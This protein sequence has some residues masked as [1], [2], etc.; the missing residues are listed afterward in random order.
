M[1]YSRPMRWVFVL[2]LGCLAGCATPGTATPMATSTATATPQIGVMLITRVRPTTAVSQTTPTPLPTPTATPTP[3]PIV[4]RIE[5]GDTLLDLALRHGYTVADIE[6]LNPGIQP[7]LLQI[8]QPVLL[9][10]PPTAVSQ[11]ARAT[12][13]PLQLRVTQAQL[14]RTT[15]ESVWVVGELVNEGAAAV[16]GVRLQIDVVD[17]AGE[18]VA[19]T[20]VWVAASLIPP[21]AAAPFG[22]LLP[23]L[24]PDVQP[25]VSVVGGQSAV[26]LGSRYVGVQPTAVSLT[27]SEGQITLTGEL[28]NTG[29]HPASQLRLIA[30][31]YDA[32][33]Q[34]SGFQVQ[35]WADGVLGV[36][37]KR[38]F[39]LTAAP[40]GGAVVGYGLLVQGIRD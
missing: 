12:P 24:P 4:Y 27:S 10:P 30:T 8:G 36:E 11:L 3:T 40:P 31:F 21:G 2:L 34:I 1:L 32:A 28:E 13:V 37:E 33:G 22:T 23:S 25:V 19:Q 26:D 9:P 16:E 18:R 38:P 35:E 29:E 5:A 15:A 14:Y 7:E 20:A 39:S 6:A 17:G